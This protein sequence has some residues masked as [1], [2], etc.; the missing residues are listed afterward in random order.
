MDNDLG[1]I[2]DALPGLVW[3]AH[4]D[5]SVEFL[6]A[7]WLEYTGLTRDDVSTVGWESVIH[8]DDLAKVLTT[9]ESICTSG[10][11]GEMEARLRRHDGQYR[12]FSFRASP[13]LNALGEVIRWYGINTDIQDRRAAEEAQFATE[14]RFRMIVEGLPA[15]VTLMSPAGELEF[16]NR[17]V[18]EYFGVRFLCATRPV[19]S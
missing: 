5:G 18:L 3:T 17:H 13:I 19:T 14:E 15:L 6:N 7:R 4:P 16:A 1:Q 10:K 12:W 8:V 9:W 2:V 11:L